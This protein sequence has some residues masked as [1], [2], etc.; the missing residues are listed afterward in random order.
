MIEATRHLANFIAE[1]KFE[2]LPPETIAKAKI[3]ILDCLG[4]SIGAYPT[5]WAQAVIELVQGYQGSEE[6]HLFVDGHKVPAI[7]AALVNGTLA[8]SLEFDDAHI[9]STCHPGAPIIPAALAVAEHNESSGKDVLLSIILAYE[10]MLRVGTAIFPSHRDDRKFHITATTG[11]LGAA[12]AAAKLLGL[13]AKG[14]LY[15]LGL[16]GD[17]AASG[18]F[19]FI[20]DGSMSKRL[21]AG[22]A[23]M[24]GVLS[25][26]LAQRG[27]T[28]GPAIL[29]DN[30]GFLEAYADDYDVQVLTSNLGK[31][32]EILNC[33]CKQFP[34]CG[35]LQGLI[36]LAVE[37]KKEHDLKVEDIE[38]VEIGT[39]R[40][41]L[42]HNKYEITSPLDAQESASFAVAASLIYG[43]AYIREFFEKYNDPDILALM[44][45]INVRLDQGVNQGRGAKVTVG[46]KQGVRLSGQENESVTVSEEIVVEKFERLTMEILPLNQI[47]QIIML[48]QRLESEK[49]IENLMRLTEKK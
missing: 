9:V 32:F 34:C 28:G 13:D 41:A 5:P 20:S 36:R 39:Y 16:A 42:V 29:E 12:A 49:N 15:A 19:S 17:Q 14:C 4:V 46:M 21:H 38:Y 33:W 35:H 26:L 25:A 1:T 7:N 31:D 18:L 27:V 37:I 11:N 24:N 40:D 3:H 48:A 22:R 8:H 10:I 6:A 23:A 44:K 43:D 2:D 45:R 47:E 30:Y